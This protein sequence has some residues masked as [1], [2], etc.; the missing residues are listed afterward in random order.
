MDAVLMLLLL[1][2]LRQ[3]EP[4]ALHNAPLSCW[5][6]ILRDYMAKDMLK[7]SGI[8]SCSSEVIIKFIELVAK[9]KN[10][11]NVMACD[12]GDQGRSYG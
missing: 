5:R 1:C 3:H 4:G 8:E 7:L 10:F 12:G 6:N 2:E 9:C 11:V